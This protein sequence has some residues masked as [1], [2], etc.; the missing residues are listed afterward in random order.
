MTARKRFAD[1]L[2]EQGHAGVERLPAARVPGVRLRGVGGPAVR[3]EHDDGLARLREVAI[4]EDVEE[5]L[6]EAHHLAAREDK[7]RADVARV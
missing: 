4:P 3:H 2:V 7:G 6:P 1:E 5:G